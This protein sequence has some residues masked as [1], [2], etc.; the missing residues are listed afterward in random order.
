[1]TTTATENPH[2]SSTQNLSIPQQQPL[3]LQINKP[4]TTFQNPHSIEDR[5]YTFKIIKRRSPWNKKEDEA[6]INLVN[7]H[8]TGNWTIIANEM[9]NIYNFKNRSGK[10]CRERWHNHLDPNVK[11]DDWTENE[12]NILFSKHMEFGNKWSDIAIFLPGR[13]DNAIKN[14]FYSKLRKY[15]RKILKQINKENLM[16]INGIDSNKYN[17]DKIYKMLKKFKIAYKNLNKETV[18]ELIISTEKNLKGNNNNNCKTFGIEIQAPKNKNKKIKIG[19]NNNNNNNN[20]N[21]INNGN[22][23]NN[24]DMKMKNNNNNNSNNKSKIKKSKSK[25][26]NFLSSNLINNQNL[27]NNNNFNKK[28]L[29]INTK[30]INACHSKN[31]KKENN[32]NNN[33]NNNFLYNSILK[34]NPQKKKRKNK[35]RKVSICLSTPE[36]KKTQIQKILPQRKFSFGDKYNNNNRRRK[37]KLTQDDFDINLNNIE[38]V[39]DGLE[40]R[41]NNII[42]IEKS[43]LNNNQNLIENEEFLNPNINNINIENNENNNNTKKTKF[44]P[45]EITIPT[46]PKYTNGQT[47]RINY[48]YNNNNNIY[49]ERFTYYENNQPQISPM[50]VNMIYLNSARNLFNV[51]ILSYENPKFK[52]GNYYNIPQTPF[53]NKEVTLNNKVLINNNESKINFDNSNTY[54]IN[55]DFTSDVPNY[56]NYTLTSTTN[57]NNNTYDNYLIPSS[58]NH[59]PVIDINLINQSDTN[60]IFINN[61]FSPLNNNAA[62]FHKYFMNNSNFN[63]NNNNNN[64][65]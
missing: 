49:D 42:I 5:Q 35:R 63:H 64:I 39:R 26:K 8:G 6:I 22:N 38:I 14:H 24:I 33:N 10:Q 43:I 31:K 16:K 13:T 52:N 41:N 57:M 55:E 28:K 4:Q 29:T 34:T 47:P 1:M 25:N 44:R 21:I 54:Q 61:N 30:K 7:K 20:N 58:R 36:N 46:T 45:L 27:N 17:S 53:G 65:F 23:N 18:L 9:S 60:N 40:I 19:L 37:K 56:N 12:E 15:I 50:N 2:L 48:N 62:N 59:K 11:K 32:N 3:N 51:D